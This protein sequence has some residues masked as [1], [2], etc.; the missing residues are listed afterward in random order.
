MGRYRKCPAWTG[1]VTATVALDGNPVV[2]F[3]LVAPIMAV[4]ADAIPL[5]AQRT[6][7][8]RFRVGIFIRKQ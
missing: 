7:D 1:G 4:A 3:E 5:T 6:T 8:I 2:T